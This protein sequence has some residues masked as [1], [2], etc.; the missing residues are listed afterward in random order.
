MPTMVV[1]FNNTR[2]NFKGLF[3]GLFVFIA[4]FGMVFACKA[5]VTPTVPE[6]ERYTVTFHFDGKTLSETYTAG[7]ELELLTEEE[8]GISDD[9]EIKDWY[10]DSGFTEKAH[11]GTP[12]NSNLD[13][14]VK[15]TKI[16]T[17]IEYTVKLL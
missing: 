7:E 3:L 13:I 4:V 14:Y 1:N 16:D 9:Y 11:G 10:L 15:L 12:V 6:P 8:A 2:L 17:S 5:P